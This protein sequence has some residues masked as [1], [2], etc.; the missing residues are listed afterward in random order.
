MTIVISAFF[1]TI[2]KQ[3]CF[4][5]LKLIKEIN[6]RFLFLLT[7]NLLLFSSFSYAETKFPFYLNVVGEDKSLKN[8]VRA[9][10]K[11]GF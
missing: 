6:M 1:L 10:T 11:I 3:K 5:L 9:K 7:L 2:F 4:V 8:L